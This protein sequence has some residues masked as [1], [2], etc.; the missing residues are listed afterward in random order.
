LSSV[1]GRAGNESARPDRQIVDRIDL[2]IER[3]RDVVPY[4]LESRMLQEVGDVAPR[5]RVIVV[6]AHDLNARNEKPLAEMTAEKTGTASDED[7][8]W[9][10]M[11]VGHMSRLLQSAHLQLSILLGNTAIRDDCKVRCRAWSIVSKRI[12]D[13]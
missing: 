2:D 13:Q 7:A 4:G 5:A 11:N 8:G 1:R 3:E 12:E 9:P 6:D 10:H